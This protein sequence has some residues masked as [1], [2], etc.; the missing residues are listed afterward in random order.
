MIV[1][2]ENSSNEFDTWHGPIKVKATARLQKFFKIYHNT[3]C[4]VLSLCYY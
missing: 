4:S 2:Y 1:E 3:N